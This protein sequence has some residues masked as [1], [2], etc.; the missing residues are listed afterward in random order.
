MKNLNTTLKVIVLCI[1]IIPLTGLVISSARLFMDV[2]ALPEPTEEVIAE[3]EPEPTAET[4]AEGGPAAVTIAP[5]PTPTVPISEAVAGGAAVGAVGGVSPTAVPVSSRKVIVLDPGHGASSG[6]MSAAEKREAGWVQNSSGAWGEWRHWKSGTYGVDCEGS[7]CVGDKT[8]WYPI[9]SSDRSTEP[10]IN[11]QN[12]LAAKSRLEELGYTVRLTRESNSENPSM[13][14]RVSN[15]FSST[16]VLDACLYV[17]IHSNA[18]G[19]SG[20]AYISLGS[21]SIYDQKYIPDG[22][23]SISNTAGKVINDKIV[24]ETS[25][26]RSGGGSIGGEGYLILFHKCPVPIAYL[27]IGFFDNSSDLSILNSEYE[28]IGTAIA[29]GIDEYLS[30][31]GG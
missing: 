3:A 19:G 7:G 22:F 25:L 10:Q 29:D 2:R 16:G 1:C 26:K 9:G 12:A 6:S 23:A 4:E 8:C 30:S 5:E 31:T 27:E 21:E 28:K 24:S 18:G 14:K 15:C 20:T 13:T 17:C 11:L